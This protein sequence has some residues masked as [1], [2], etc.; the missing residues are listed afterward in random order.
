MAYAAQFS[1]Y[2]AFLYKFLLF[3]QSWS[4]KDGG[5][6]VYYAQTNQIKYEHL[7]KTKMC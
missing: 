5:G 2:N 6:Y 1:V 4:I 3:Q 7:V